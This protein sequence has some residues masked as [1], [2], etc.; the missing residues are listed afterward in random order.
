MKEQEAKGLLSGSG[1][2]T[3]LNKI[4]LFGDIFFRVYKMNEIANKFLLAGDK[5]MA[6]LHLK[7]P[8]FTYSTCGLFTKNRER[9]EKFMKTGNTDFIYRNEF[10]KACFPHHMA[11]GKSKDLTKRTQS[12]KV[13]RDKT[14]KVASDPRYD[15][16]QRGLASMVK[17]L[18]EVVLM[19]NQIINSQINFR[20]RLLKNLR[21]KKSIL[22]LEPI[23]EVLI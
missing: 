8:G 1:I 5:F 9:T 7:Q 16:F 2:K 23:F 21:D 22:L 4:Q 17:N 19:L 13:L 10:D 12:D 15:G 3:L 20:N 6:E 14:F 11:Y 18:V